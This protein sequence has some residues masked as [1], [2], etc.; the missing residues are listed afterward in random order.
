MVAQLCRY[1]ENDWIVHCKWVNYMIWDLSLNLGD[2]SKT[3]THRLMGL[4]SGFL[5]QWCGMKPNK[6]P[7]L[8]GPGDADIAGVGHILRT[9]ALG[10]LE[11]QTWKMSRIK[12][13]CVVIR[14]QP[15]LKPC[16]SYCVQHTA[17]TSTEHWLPQLMW[18]LP[19]GLAWIAA[20]WYPCHSSCPWE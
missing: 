3:H 5:I 7:F 17:T 6:L 16:H 1:T 19:L 12:G 18:Q 20:Y 15:Q 8:Q 14:T 4:P 13:G 9:I 2:I 10:S 11:K